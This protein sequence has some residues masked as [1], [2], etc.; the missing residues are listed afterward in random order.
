[1]ASPLLL[2]LFDKLPD[3]RADDDE[4]LWAAGVQ[5]AMREFRAGVRERYTEGTLQRMLVSHDARTRR[6]AVLGLGF[7]G[8][9]DSNAAVAALLQDDDA[10][11][12]RFAADAL[13]EL[14]FRGGSP[15]QNARLSDAAKNPDPAATL[16][17]LDELI[18][19]APDFAEAHNQRAIQFYK[20]GD[21]ARAVADCE[22]VLRLNPFHF[23]AAAGMGQCLAK[24]GKRRAAL[25]AFRSAL[26]INPGLEHLR[27]TIRELE[28]SLGRGE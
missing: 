22:T 13:W 6:A 20:R 23:G 28:Q 12:Q 25:R 18:A 1:M 5:D 10:L 17:E 14:W 19:E 21:Y 26:E 7:I 8:T 2:E 27:E 3:L 4:E 16:A 24:L 11:V 9:M 15:E